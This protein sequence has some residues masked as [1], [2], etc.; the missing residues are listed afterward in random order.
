[1]IFITII[2][3]IMRYLRAD[4]NLPHLSA[5]RISGRLRI[6]VLIRVDQCRGG[7]MFILEFPQN[8]IGFLFFVIF[9]KIK[10]CPYR[11]HHDA[12]VVH[13]AG[14]WGAATLSKYIFADDNYYQNSYI[15]NHEYG[16]R[17]QSR[18]LV[19]L[20]LPAIGMPSFLWAGVYTI[21]RS[22]LRK[23][24]FWFYTEAWANKLV[25]QHY[26]L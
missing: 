8:L 18:L 6:C 19:F 26:K 12:F 21:L 20:Y 7:V 17:V 23:S 9:A 4:A 3:K 16:H 13:V 1:M 5:T 24:Y 15:I 10:K 25:D 14:I 11:K 2:K 22:K